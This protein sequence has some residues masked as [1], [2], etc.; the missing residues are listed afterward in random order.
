MSAKKRKEA[1]MPATTAGLLRFF[2]EESKGIKVRPEIVLGV[3]AAFIVVVLIL[4]A[5]FPI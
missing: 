2:E 3:S 1:P 5:F 4:R